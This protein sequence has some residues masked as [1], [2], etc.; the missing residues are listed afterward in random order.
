MS[1]IA[2]SVGLGNV[3]RFPFTALENG[4]GAFVIPYIIVLLLV[5]KP[6]YYLEMLLGQFSSR[7]N[8]KVYDLSPAMRGIYKKKK[9]KIINQSQKAFCLLNFVIRFFKLFISWNLGVGYGQTI[10]TI[11][12]STYYT[13]LMAITVKY[14]IS[15]FN[16]VLPWSECKDEWMPYCFSS[17]SNKSIVVNDLQN[18]TKAS[19][20]EYYFM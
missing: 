3:W 4:G 10:T 13:S 6:I 12:A 17:T 16:S 11:I 19:S 5:G 15:S 7:G 9:K 1:C 8:I 20:A 2:C 18:I 14:F